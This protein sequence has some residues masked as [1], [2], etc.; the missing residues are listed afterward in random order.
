MALLDVS[1]PEELGGNNGTPRPRLLASATR[2]PRKSPWAHST[3][4][5]GAVRWYLR[6]HT[7]MQTQL[8]SDTKE[9][10]GQ[11]HKEKHPL[12]RAST[13]TGELH[14]DSTLTATI[15]HS[16]T[17]DGGAHRK[18]QAVGISPSRPQQEFLHHTLAA[19]GA[20]LDE[21]DGR[22]RGPNTK[23]T[24][25]LQRQHLRRLYISH[26]DAK[27]EQL[28]ATVTARKKEIAAL[29]KQVAQLGRSLHVAR[30]ELAPEKPPPLGGARQS[31]RAIQKKKTKAN[32]GDKIYTNDLEKSLAL[33]SQTDDDVRAELDEKM[34]RLRS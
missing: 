26:M 7:P 14:D 8:T 34:R 11:S 5:G 32:I 18:Q 27:Q 25:A 12:T 33:Q 4:K 19:I 30:E 29:K 6:N 16:T 1:P 10:E 24:S 21:E 17:L 15:Q 3:Q 13:M 23:A 28:Q 9:K 22:P 2:M 20:E 31:Q